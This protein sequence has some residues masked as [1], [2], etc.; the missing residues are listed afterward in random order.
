MPARALIQKLNVV[1]CGMDK[2]TGAETCPSEKNGYRPLTPDC[3]AC[4][5]AREAEAWLADPENNDK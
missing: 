3:F 1:A 5:I 2:H 4:K